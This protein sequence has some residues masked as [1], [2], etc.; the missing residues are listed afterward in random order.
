M[1]NKFAYIAFSLLPGILLL[2]LSSGFAADWA[3]SGL[4][5]YNRGEFDEART[6]FEEALKQDPDNPHLIYI[7]A[8]TH[9][10][11]GEHGVAISLYKKV[12]VLHPDAQT[13]S[14]TDMALRR[15]GE[16]ARMRNQLGNASPGSSIQS[17]AAIDRQTRELTDNYAEQEDAI[18]ASV[19]RGAAVESARLKSLY[20]AE[21]ANIRAASQR[22]AS[23]RYRGG[24]Y[25]ST[26]DTEA[27]EIDLYSA[28]RRRAIESAAEDRVERHEIAKQKVSKGLAQS[29]AN[30]E[31]QMKTPSG[32][33]QLN[34]SGTNLYV[35]SY[36]VRSKSLDKELKQ[37]VQ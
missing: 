27:Q 11:L 5:H 31:R 35:R 18:K 25:G 23:S 28:A 24:S 20:D 14:N 4:D 8:N 12:L 16:I 32:T 29:A 2:S 13:A 3:N 19:R 33:V 10:A 1:K 34:P 9:S 30:L 26:T 7:L 36:V 17:N 22:R 21:A 37:P 6:A 15:Y